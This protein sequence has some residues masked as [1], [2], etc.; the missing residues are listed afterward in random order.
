MNKYLIAGAVLSALALAPVAN[1]DD[2]DVLPDLNNVTAN[3]ANTGP[4]YHDKRNVAVV[5]ESM[6]DGHQH[7]VGVLPDLGNFYAAVDAAGN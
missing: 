7:E 3:D 1:A 5:P 2:S 6:Y 4:L